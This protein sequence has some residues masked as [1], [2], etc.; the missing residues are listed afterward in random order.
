MTTNITVSTWKCPQCGQINDLKDE[1]CPRCDMANSYW[2]ADTLGHRGTRSA[3]R[4]ADPILLLV[5]V[6]I[7]LA[8]AAWFGAAAR[9]LADSVGPQAVVSSD[10]SGAFGITL[11]AGLN[12]STALSDTSMLLDRKSVV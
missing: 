4:S 7:V 5:G 12:R 6:A 8:F 10:G 1:R 2:N 9:E 11:G 3:R